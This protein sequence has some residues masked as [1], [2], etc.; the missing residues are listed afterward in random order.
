M[1]Y[2]DPNA[3]IEWLCKAFGFTERAA[4]KGA[5]GQVVHAE[6]VFG[7]GMIMLGP[8]NKGEFAERFMTTPAETS[9]RCTQSIYLIVDDVDA[10]HD[11]AAAAGAEIVMPPS[12]PEYGGRAYAAKDLEGHV[13]S[14]GTYDPWNITSS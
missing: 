7:N 3:A 6:L 1:N 5:D 2:R 8:F 13:W 4:Y 14:F 11:R 10:H 12:D 9:G